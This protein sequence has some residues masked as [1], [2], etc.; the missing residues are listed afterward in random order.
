MVPG[1]GASRADEAGEDAL[2]GDPDDEDH[3]DGGLDARDVA[4]GVVSDTD[5]ADLVNAVGGFR[6]GAFLAGAL[7]GDALGVLGSYLSSSGPAQRGG[8]TAGPAVPEAPG[9]PSR[10]AGE[11]GSVLCHD[12]VVSGMLGGSP[13]GDGSGEED[14]DEVLRETP[15]GLPM[16]VMGSLGDE[17]GD[18]QAEQDEEGGD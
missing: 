7:G 5:L 16:W 15:P 10:D 1:A 9:S 4:A 14:E 12:D 3:D 11:D 6:S 2:A 18:H 13:T 8:R 17:E